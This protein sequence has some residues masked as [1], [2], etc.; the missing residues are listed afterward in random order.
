[1]ELRKRCILTMQNQEKA[2]EHSVSV[3]KKKYVCN[4]VDLCH[5]GKMVAATFTGHCMLYC[6]ALWGIAVCELNNRI[7]MSVIFTTN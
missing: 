2:V 5:G 1:M 3:A 6:H 7:N 4:Y